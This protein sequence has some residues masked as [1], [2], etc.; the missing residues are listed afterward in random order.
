M[1]IEKIAGGS[2]TAFRSKRR[3]SLGG[4]VSSF[5]DEGYRRL[6][7]IPD[8][9]QGRKIVVSPIVDDDKGIKGKSTDEK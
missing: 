5:M 1:S 2:E 4:R 7:P 9:L 3:A 8:R 6:D